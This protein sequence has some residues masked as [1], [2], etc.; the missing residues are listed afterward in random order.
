MIRCCQ[1][2]PDEQTE[3]QQVEGVTQA[4]PSLQQRENPRAQLPTPGTF[5]GLTGRAEL[6]ATGSRLLV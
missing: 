2:F 5:W 1:R 6:P 4:R 3:A